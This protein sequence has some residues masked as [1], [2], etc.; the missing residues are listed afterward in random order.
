[1]IPHLV[2]TERLDD[3]AVARWAEQEFGAAELG[4]ARRTARLVALATVLARKPNASFPAAFD[5]GAQL[6]GTYR[7][8]ANPAI[9]PEAILAPHLQAT[10]TRLQALPRVLAV[11]DTT[12]LD[13]TDHAATTGL[14]PLV[15][16]CR[17]GLVVHSTLAFS[18]ERVPLGVLAQDVWARDRA[19]YAAQPDH[20]TR[21]IE[22]KE[23]AKW[24]TS[25]AAL[26]PARAA[27]PTTHLISVGDREA[28]V[29][30]LFIQPRPEGVDLLVRAT[31][32]RAVAE[33]QRRLWA[34]VSA[35][36]VSAELTVTVP[37]QADRPAR[38]ARLSLRWRAVQLKPPRHRAQEHLPTVRVWAVWAVELAPPSGVPPLDWFLLTTVPIASAADASQRLEWYSVRWGIEVWH[39]VLKSGCRLE[40]R[41]LETAE[42]LRRSL[43][44]FSVIAWRILYAV[45]LS[46]TVPTHSCTLLLEADEWQALYCFI[47]Q[48][49]VAPTEPPN[50]RQAVR[51]IAQLGGFPN[52][53]SDG[54][55]GATVLW[56]GFQRLA[57]ITQMF[58]VMRPLPRHKNV[59]KD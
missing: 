45:W 15:S 1:M 12:Y 38:Q 3:E 35:Q 18:L 4:D 36:P 53:K 14:G 7:F 50:L 44:V 27:C 59:G 21:P 30:D 47:H 56:R 54:E 43:S 24:L 31:Q 52:R 26:R 16:A 34:A 6:K 25:L 32:D 5:D 22:E 23:S 39:K 13:W 48:V 49:A 41:Q 46:R 9:E 37:R 58:H 28:D 10:Y 11:Q 51:W 33:P 57:D 19:T 55:P 8:F 2:E 20:K 42:R 29:Y 17:Q 40:Q